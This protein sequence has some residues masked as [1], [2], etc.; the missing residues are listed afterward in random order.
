MANNKLLYICGASF[1]YGFIRSIN[2]RHD[3][4]LDVIGTKVVTAFANGFFYAIP[5]YTPYYLL[6]LV[7]RID[8]K[9]SGKDPSKYPDEYEDMFSKNNNVFF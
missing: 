7:N 8:I 4:P 5:L 1:T 2:G 9:L 3:K 6:K